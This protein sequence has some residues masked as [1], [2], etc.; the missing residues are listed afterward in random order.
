MPHGGNIFGG[1]DEYAAADIGNNRAHSA[2]LLP[3]DGGGG[4]SAQTIFSGGG[5]A[6]EGGV[7]RRLTFPPPKKIVSPRITGRQI[8]RRRNVIAGRLL[9]RPVSS[10]ATY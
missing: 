10:G 9:C 3:L 6:T 5:N 4:S 1:A 7:N 8:T 2:L